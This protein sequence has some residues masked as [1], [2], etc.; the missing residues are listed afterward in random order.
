MRKLIGTLALGT[1]L[2][3]VAGAAQ[4][5]E[6]WMVVGQ[7]ATHDTIVSLNIDRIVGT[8]EKT[9]WLLWVGRTPGESYVMQAMV[10]RCADHTVR[11]GPSTVVGEDGRAT[12][13]PG[14][15]RF[16]LS[17]PGTVID[18]AGQYVCQ[19]VVPPNGDL[20]APDLESAVEAGKAVLS[21]PD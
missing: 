10:F 17:V 20:V 7:T 4:A 3:A 12:S 6:R 8:S 2:A 5:A 1:A 21:S 18:V 16:E 14:G 13:K 19:G 15:T 9:A 11:N